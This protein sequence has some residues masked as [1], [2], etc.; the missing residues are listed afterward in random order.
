MK[1]AILLTIFACLNFFVTFAQSSNGIDMATG[2]RSS[3]KIYVVVIVL[4]II[5]VGFIIY[6]FTMDRRV[7]RLEKTNRKTVKVPKE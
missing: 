4:L 7:S 3:G 6:L 1:K 2:L 5:F